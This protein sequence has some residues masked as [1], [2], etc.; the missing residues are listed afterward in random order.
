MT[1]A[2]VAAKLTTALSAHCSQADACRLL[3]QRSTPH[4][5]LFSTFV[6]ADTLYD[7]APPA[8][9]RCA[10]TRACRAGEPGGGAGGAQL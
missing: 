5:N 4:C 6:Y 7:A 10:A 2:F 3:A 9:R 1:A 8:G